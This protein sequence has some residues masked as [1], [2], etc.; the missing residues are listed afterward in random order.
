M[1]APW[2]D[3]DRAG[4]ARQLGT[5]PG[6]R[7]VAELIQNAWD[8]DVTMVTVAVHQQGAG[9][10][11]VIV[12]DDNPDGFKDLSHAWTLFAP[13]VK[14][15]DTT[16]RGRFNMGEKLLLAA[17]RFACIQ[18]TTGA[19]TFYK[20]GRRQSYQMKR[21][22]GSRISVEL[23]LTDKVAAI[24]AGLQRLQPPAN[25]VTTINGARLD[26][27]PVI[28]TV[29]AELPTVTTDDEGQFRAT[30]RTCPVRILDMG[31]PAM[32]YEMGIP[33]VDVDLPWSVDVGQK[34]PLN[35]D[36]DNV[37]PAYLQTLR[38]LALNA[39]HGTLTGEQ[40]SQDWARAAAGDERADQGAVGQSLDARFGPKRVAFDPN[41]LE[42]NRLAVAAG[43][44]VVHG[45]SLSA[46][47]WANARPTTKP[48]GQVTPSPK[49]FTPGGRPLQLWTGDPALVAS[50][51]DLVHRLARLALGRD[52]TIVLAADGGWP[53]RATFGPDYVLHLNLTGMGLATLTSL[54][55]RQD[56]VDLLIHEFAHFDGSQHFT[57]QYWRNLSRVGAR[58]VCAVATR[59]HVFVMEE[60]PTS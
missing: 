54:D 35:R 50:H 3:V 2:F 57:E 53:F 42:G 36:R 33:V 49:P 47:E 5:V 28:A 6:W 22:A 25:I 11:S 10:V 52:I 30:R 9:F 38:V 32:V 1:K 37:T 34:V 40:F 41:D 23:K 56:L 59:P 26:R 24:V 16:K 51:L 45:G 17:A 60:G 15:A 43:Y 4:L 18:T 55:L 29:V 19:V 14:A 12:E 13:S 20:E 46:G 7:L 21:K 39:M 8:E 48:A 44:T 27:R 31:Q 58:L